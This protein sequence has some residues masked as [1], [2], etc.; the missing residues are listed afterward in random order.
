M[1]I[2]NKS[3]INAI[4]VN[5][6]HKFFLT[7][8]FLQVFYFIISIIILLFQMYDI[9]QTIQN[10]AFYFLEYHQIHLIIGCF[11]IFIPAPVPVPDN[12][13]YYKSRLI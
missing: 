10:S 1:Y 9:L 2:D 12:I 3:T 7:I 13:M 4:I 6:T 5:I 8:L 11:Q